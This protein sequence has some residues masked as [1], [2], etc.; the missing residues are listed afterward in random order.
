MNKIPGSSTAR[1]RLKLLD[2]PTA[3]RSSWVLHCEQVLVFHRYPWRDWGELMMICVL[4][5]PHPITPLYSL[6]TASRD[7]QAHKQNSSPFALCSPPCPVT[8]ETEPDGAALMVLR[9]IPWEAQPDP[10]NP[11]IQMSLA[12]SFVFSTFTFMLPEM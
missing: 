3:L 7:S 2:L 11:I 4:F 8:P 9:E 5:C 10:P 12:G 1:S 6:H